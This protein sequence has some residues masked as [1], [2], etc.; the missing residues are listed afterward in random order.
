LWL[1]ILFIVLVSLLGF[2]SEDGSN[3]NKA[4][5]PD[6]AATVQNTGALDWQKASHENRLAVAEVII[7]AMQEAD[8]LRPEISHK[9][10]SQGAIKIYSEELRSA[11]DGAFE[12]LPNAVEN[13]KMFVNQ[14]V[15]ETAVI[16]ATMMGWLR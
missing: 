7:Y 2:C 4:T 11:I 12:P 15:K 9:I 5:A 6:S 10:S 14:S 16:L 13:E 1:I 8:M 3:N